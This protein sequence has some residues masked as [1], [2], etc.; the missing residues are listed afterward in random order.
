MEEGEKDAKAMKRA[1]EDFATSL[2]K[3]SSLEPPAAVYAKEAREYLESGKIEEGL[4]LRPQWLPALARQDTEPPLVN[5]VMPLTTRS[6]F[7]EVA[8]RERVFMMFHSPSCI[9]C[10][11]LMPKFEGA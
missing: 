6:F 5:S 3:S 9:H 8:K 11:N 2:E 4:E 1:L 10:K 7:P